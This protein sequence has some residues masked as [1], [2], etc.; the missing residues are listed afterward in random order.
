MKE[1]PVLKSCRQYLELMGYKV[2]RNNTGKGWFLPYQQGKKPPMGARWIEFGEKGS[3][4]LIACSPTGRYLEIE[5]KSTKGKQTP[6]QVIREDD[7]KS[8]NGVYIVAYSTDDLE[9]GL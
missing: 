7:I 4:D 5:T 1:S 8:R 3:G 9:R 6:E 2:I